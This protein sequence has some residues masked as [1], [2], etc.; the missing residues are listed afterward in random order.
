MVKSQSRPYKIW[1]QLK[2]RCDNP[3]HSKYKIYGGKGISYPEKWKSFDGFWEDMQNGYSE[4]LT[5]DRVDSNCNYSKENCRWVD[6]KE[7]NNN[8]SDNLKLEC[9]GKIYTV[10]EL[11]EVTGLLTT[12]IYN[13]LSR[14]W[15]VEQIIQTHRLKQ[16]EYP[17]SR[18]SKKT[19]VFSENGELL[20]EFDSITDLSKYIN[21]SYDVTKNILKGKT[22]KYNLDIRFI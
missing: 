22:K 11:A 4:K 17:S 20:K 9:D 6:Y 5:I 10:N 8:K 16:G 13:R 18:N 12:T 14:G 15:G 19:G 1:T 2:S 3:N 21:L 7:Q